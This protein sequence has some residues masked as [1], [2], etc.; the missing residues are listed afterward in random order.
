MLTLRTLLEE[1]DLHLARGEGTVDSPVRWVHITELDDPTPRWTSVDD[2]GGI[3]IDVADHVATATMVRADKH[4]AL[5][6]AMFEALH[7]AIDRLKVEPGVRAVVLCGEGKSFCSGL[8][9]ASFMAEGDSDGAGPDSLLAPVEGVAANYAQ[10]VATG[11]SEVPVAVIAAIHGYCFG[12]GLQIALGADIRIAAPDA[13]LSVMESRW[14]LIPDMGITRALP[15]L[16]GIDVA[17]E[18]TF[19][20]RRFSG[21]EAARLGVVTR[22]ITDPY[23]AARELAAEIAQRS[24]EAVRGAKR[25]YDESWTAPAEETLALE[26]ALQRS[27]MGSPNQIAAV[28]AGMSKQPAEFTDPA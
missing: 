18:L 7:A 11:W 28:M 21:E 23:A 10:Q 14:G 8:D 13:A 16:V 12:G 24:P 2:M 22:T 15:R 6:R 26:E 1:I 3:R 9:I 17:K 25:L 19:T 5:D 4:N 20:G 27:L